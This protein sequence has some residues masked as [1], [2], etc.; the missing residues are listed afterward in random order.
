MAARSAAPKREKK[1]RSSLA[2]R[3]AAE[4][5]G[6]VGSSS[7]AKTH[8]SKSAMKRQKHRAR[9]QLAGSKEG[10]RELSDMMTSIEEELPASKADDTNELSPHLSITAKSRR[11]MLCVYCLPADTERA[12]ASANHTYLQT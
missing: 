10:L 5:A 6:E 2:A 9:E 4:R 12:S 11:A 1:T 7:S 8:L 3:L